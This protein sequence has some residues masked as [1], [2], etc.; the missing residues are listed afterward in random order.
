MIADSRIILPRLPLQSPRLQTGGKTS[1][2]LSVATGH[3]KHP[4]LHTLR[5]AK[6]RHRFDAWNPRSKT[7]M[8]GC[9]LQKSLTINRGVAFFAQFA[10]KIFRSFFFINAF[11]QAPPTLGTQATPHFL[12]NSSPHQ[13]DPSLSSTLH[14]LPRPKVQ[15]ILLTLPSQG[16]H[17]HCYQPRTSPQHSAMAW[18]PLLPRLSPVHRSAPPRHLTSPNRSCQHRSPA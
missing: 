9:A 1:W 2:P 11:S 7:P 5:V 8:A 17:D 14:H 4:P 10:K 12:T 18:N 6:Q 15:T 3:G 16:H 13:R